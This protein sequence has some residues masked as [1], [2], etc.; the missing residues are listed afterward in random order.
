MP[1]GIF[2]ILDDIAALPNDASAL[3]NVSQIN[4]DILLRRGF[5]YYESA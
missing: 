5:R 3:S 4:T 1:S 2:A